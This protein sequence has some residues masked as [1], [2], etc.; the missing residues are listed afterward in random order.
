MSLT[1]EPGLLKGVFAVAALLLAS[2]A[3]A[4]VSDPLES[5]GLI[6]VIF[7]NGDTVRAISAEPRPFEMLRLIDEFQAERTLSFNR[8]R[9]VL[10][11][12]GVD[13]TEDALKRRQTIG[14]PYGPSS[15]GSP[16][17]TPRRSRIDPRMAR[18]YPLTELSAFPRLGSDHP[19]DRESGFTLDLGRAFKVGARTSLGASLFASVGDGYADLGLRPRV[20]RWLGRKSSVDFAPGLIV[21]H[22]EP[23]GWRPHGPGFVGQVALNHS[24]YLGVVVQAYT[25][26]RSGPARGSWFDPP[27]ARVT[28]RDSGLMLGLRLG[29][30]AGRIGAAAASV[31]GFVVVANRRPPIYA[32]IVP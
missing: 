19:R 31:I 11:E 16:R 9:R 17:R 24:E 15:P 20:R 12:T 3:H 2:G 32:P 1:N 10:D 22:D 4:S 28:E 6:T 23:A 21:T 7:T 25:V 30:K 29:G 26:R 27:S 14:K 18:S 5:P 8:V 13:R